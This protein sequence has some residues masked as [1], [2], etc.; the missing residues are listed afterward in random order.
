MKRE[1]VYQKTVKVIR[2]CM[3]D[4]RD[5]ELKEST[6]INNDVA[7]DSMGFILII[8]KLEALFDVRIPQKQW[9][10]MKSLGD[11]IDAIMKRLPAE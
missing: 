4:L 11:V 1:E 2:D 9:N 10:R 6:I 8:C 7:I 5:A 3:P